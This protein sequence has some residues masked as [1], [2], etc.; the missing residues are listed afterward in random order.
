MLETKELDSAN[1]VKLPQL[2]KRREFGIDEVYLCDDRDEKHD[3]VIGRDAL[4]KK[5]LDMLNSAQQFQ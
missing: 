2:T 3:V 1:N 5:G 4:Q